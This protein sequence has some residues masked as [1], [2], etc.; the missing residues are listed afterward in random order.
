MR[1]EVIGNHELYMGDCLE[2]LP[3]LGEVDGVVSDPSYG[4]NYV[5]GWRKEKYDKIENDNSTKV[6]LKIIDWAIQN[7]IYSTYVFGR[8]ENVKEYPKPKSIITWVKN[9][10]GSGDLKHEHARQS[11]LIFFYPGP[12]HSWGGRGQRI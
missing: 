9:N 3:T 7:V 2:I 12:C 8:W 1:K 6:T 11:E 10:H 5:S 4:M